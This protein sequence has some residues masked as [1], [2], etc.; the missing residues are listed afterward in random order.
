[1]ARSQE[2]ARVLSKC[3][4]TRHTYRAAKPF[5]DR[6]EILISIPWLI[7]ATDSDEEAIMQ[8]I[9]QTKQRSNPL[10]ELI[11]FLTE[12]V[13]AF[14]R[15]IA[16]VDELAG[17]DALEVARVAQDLGVS[18]AD[19]RALASRD[20]T[21]ADLLTRRLETLRLDP[22]SVD[23][24]LMRDLQRCCSNCDSKQLCAHELEDK[25][26]AASWP[27]YCPNEETIAAIATK[28]ILPE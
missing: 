20:K 9:M 15:K 23:P 25:P 5:E 19:L 24:A 4:G 3:L 14:W 11:S 16:A 17:C 6:T 13:K 21:A 26:R 1:V 12:A 28:P 10:V 22:T 8:T 7:R 27:K 2:V 18:A